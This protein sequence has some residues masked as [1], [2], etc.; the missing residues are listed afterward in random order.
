MAKKKQ[1]KKFK[2]VDEGKLWAI[3]SYIFILWFVPL[4][5]LKPRNKYSVYHAKQALMLFLVYIAMWFIFVILSAIITTFAYGAAMGAAAAGTYGAGL[6][7]LG[8]VSALIRFL[9]FVIYII[10]FV[11]WIMG[12][13]RAA[14]GQ[15]KAL[16]LIGKY[17]EKWFA[18]L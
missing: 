13:Y 9:S 15:E 1:V 16:P 5:V 12:I 18:K 17:A 10:L 14:T 4:W 3:L 11:L 6:G 8:L 7:V 2:N